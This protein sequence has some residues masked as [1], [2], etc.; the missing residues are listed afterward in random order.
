[1]APVVTNSI[2]LAPIKSRM[3]TLWYWLTQIHLEN[4]RLNGERDKVT[5]R[6]KKI[7]LNFIKDC[8]KL[9]TVQCSV[10]HSLYEWQNNEIIYESRIVNGTA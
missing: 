2:I 4:G 5:V 10:S 1:M 3:A 8:R 9:E 7:A 6:W